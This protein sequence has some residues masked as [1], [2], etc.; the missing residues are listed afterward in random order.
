MSRYVPKETCRGGPSGPPAFLAQRKTKLCGSGRRAGGLPRP[1]PL[2]TGR[3]VGVRA[4]PGRNT[5]PWG[6]AFRP[7][8]L[9]QATLSGTS[10]SSLAFTPLLRGLFSGRKG[11]CTYARARCRAAEERVSATSVAPRGL[12]R[13]LSNPFVR[14]SAL[15]SSSAGEHSKPHP[16]PMPQV[17]PSTPTS[18]SAHHHTTPSPTSQAQTLHTQT[19]SA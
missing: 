12:T 8:P 9:G 15:G 6:L 10:V 13:L 7:A 11:P 19:D 4:G 2:P 16:S 3:R 5:R 14:P 1:C 18:H 17:G